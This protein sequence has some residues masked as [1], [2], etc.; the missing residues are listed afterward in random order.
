[1][2]PARHGTARTPGAPPS[3]RLAPRRTV[4]SAAALET[5]RRTGG[6]PGAGR[7][8]G[9]AR[10]LSR[11]GRARFPLTAPDWP[12]SVPRPAPD[13]RT[14]LAYDTAWSRRY[15]ARLARAVLTDNVTRPLARLLADPEVVG[16][17]MLRTIDGPV[18]F[19]ANHASHVDT[20]L[21]LSCLPLPFRHRTVVAAAADYFFDRRWKAAVWSF[22]LAAIPIERT[23]VNRRSAELATELLADGWNLII[24]PEGGRSPDGWGQPFRGGAAYLSVRAAVPVVPVH[25]A[26]TRAL[27]PKGGGGIR[28]RPT[29]V[30]FGSPL[31]PAGGE[32]ARRFATRIE[33]AVAVL[34]AEANGG[35]W[36]T[37]RR[38]AARQETPALQGPDAP[39]WRRSWAL[40]TG[41]PAAGNRVTQDRVTPG[42]SWPAGRWRRSRSTT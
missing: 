3:A 2:I 25:L 35:D 22:V 4:R 42:G 18:I 41:R 32:D 26:G 34:A 12:G 1:M 38:E 10:L 19:A 37:A 27:L 14:G 21:L 15:P 31:R 9:P 36:W 23:R 16:D 13:R 20:P 17:E 8:F 30:S 7:P 6:P 24:F 11:L 29:T 40:P 28:R 5:S 39:A 33:S